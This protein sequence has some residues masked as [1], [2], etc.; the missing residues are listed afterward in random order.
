MGLSPRP[1]MSPFPT[2]SA[3]SSANAVARTIVQ[4]TPLARRLA[5]AS[6]F[7]RN[8][9]IGLSDDAPTTDIKTTSAPAA[10]AASHQIRVA[11]TID[12][13]RSHPPRTGESLHRRHD[14]GH[15]FERGSEGRRLA[16]VTHDDLDRIAQMAR[17]CGV[18]RQDTDRSA[19][20]DEARNQDTAEPAGAAG[21]EDHERTT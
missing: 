13:C 14:D 15:A 4:L 8:S 16:N 9:S 17:S 12:R 19:A 5:S 18:P 7:A 10:E 2:S 3:H 1:K 20:V 11:I 21:D 6:Y